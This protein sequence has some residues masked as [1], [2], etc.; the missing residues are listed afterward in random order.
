MSELHLGVSYFPNPPIFPDLPV[1]NSDNF[2]LNLLGSADGQPYFDVYFDQAVLA[3]F[4]IEN[5]GNDNGSVQGLDAAGNPVGA[6][7]P[8]TTS[9]YLTTSA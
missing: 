6:M 2:D 1:T 3:V 8:F 4:L 7:V 5:S 9:D